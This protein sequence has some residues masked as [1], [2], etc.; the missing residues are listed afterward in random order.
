[1]PGAKT[2]M[3]LTTAPP[4]FFFVREQ[5]AGP[6]EGYAPSV[7]EAVTAAAKPLVDAPVGR[8]ARQLR[9]PRARGGILG[10]EIEAIELP[11]DVSGR[12]VRSHKKGLPPQIEMDISPPRANRGAAWTEKR[13]KNP[14]MIIAKESWKPSRP[15]S[16]SIPAR[17]RSARPIAHGVDHGG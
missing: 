3:K 9:V 15:R 6:F 11:R 8:S 2:D 12:E 4:L 17:R 13:S 5:W 16:T 7:D 14:M 10:D 1:M